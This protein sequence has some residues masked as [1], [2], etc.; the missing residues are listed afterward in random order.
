MIFPS[1]LKSSFRLVMTLASVLALELG[2]QLRIL[3]VSP[4]IIVF[5][6][7]LRS[8]AAL[9]SLKNPCKIIVKHLSNGVSKVKAV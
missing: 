3:F 7:L 6:F 8:G 5:S 9:I 4:N 1:N 2:T